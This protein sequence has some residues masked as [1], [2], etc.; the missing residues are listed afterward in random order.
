MRLKQLSEDEMMLNLTHKFDYFL[1][2]FNQLLPDHNHIILKTKEQADAYIQ[3]NPA[4]LPHLWVPVEQHS[5]KTNNAF[6]TIY[7]VFVDHA[8][9]LMAL[10][11]DI[12]L[13]NIDHFMITTPVV[14][15]FNKR[16]YLLNKYLWS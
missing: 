14:A 7:T 13:V 15:V 10:F 6:P 5:A 1:S 11:E 8:Y 9:N 4:S 12:S 16:Y 2:A 3:E